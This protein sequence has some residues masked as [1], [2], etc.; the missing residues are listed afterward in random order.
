MKQG[1]IQRSYNAYAVRV[2]GMGNGGVGGSGKAASG[3]PK[4]TPAKETT[5]GLL[6]IE[7]RIRLYHDGAMSQLLERLAKVGCG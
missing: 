1:V 7:M 3:M 2:Q 4:V 5:E 6:C